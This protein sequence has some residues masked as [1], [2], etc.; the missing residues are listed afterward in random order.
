ML[1]FTAPIWTLEVIAVAAVCFVWIACCLT[2]AD[3][4]TGHWHFMSPNK[5]RDRSD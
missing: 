4:V 2:L 3:W 1:G 5:E